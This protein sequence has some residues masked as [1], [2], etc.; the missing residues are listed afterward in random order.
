MG[1]GYRLQD[2]I[3]EKPMLTSISRVFFLIGYRLRDGYVQ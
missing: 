2:E 1:K 3:I